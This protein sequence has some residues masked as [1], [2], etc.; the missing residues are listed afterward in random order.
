MPYMEPTSAILLTI[1]GLDWQRSRTLLPGSPWKSLKARSSAVSSR[2][3]LQPATTELPR[4]RKAILRAGEG[5]L[6]RFRYQVNGNA[7]LIAWRDYSDE[8]PEEHL[9][10]WFSHGSTTKEESLQHVVGQAG[11]VQSEPQFAPPRCE[12]KLNR[13][14]VC[15]SVFV[16]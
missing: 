8:E 13:T 12:F 6:A 9:R 11:R 14:F 1:P 15:A 16:S 3:R 10:L 4:T 7:F 5:K 2:S